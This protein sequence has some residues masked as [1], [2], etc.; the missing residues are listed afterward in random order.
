MDCPARVSESWRTYPGEGGHASR[1]VACAPFV[2]RRPVAPGGKI[3]I[4]F[5]EHPGDEGRVLRGSGGKA[6]SRTKDGWCG[7]CCAL[8][9]R[10]RAEEGEQVV[11]VPGGGARRMTTLT[12][13]PRHE[14][15]DDRQD[16]TRTYVSNRGT[17]MGPIDGHGHGRMM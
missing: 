15:K 3:T 17:V 14:T 4:R 6:R 16:H 1:Q 2:L 8:E 12:G 11:A 5:W 7:T 10:A 13:S 9:A